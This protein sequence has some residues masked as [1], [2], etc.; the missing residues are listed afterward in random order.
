MSFCT[1]SSSGCR[2]AF[3]AST[4]SRRRWSRWPSSARST[5]TG[6]TSTASRDATLQ[7]MTDAE[8]RSFCDETKCPEDSFCESSLSCPDDEDGVCRCQLKCRESNPRPRRDT[9]DSDEPVVM[10]EV[11]PSN[12]ISMDLSNSENSDESSEK[13]QKRTAEM[14]SIL[15]YNK[16]L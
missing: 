7:T 2:S 1:T 8:C 15:D 16:P 9:Q 14:V 4:R 10:V 3:P 12:P 13:N 6:T 11:L 5:S